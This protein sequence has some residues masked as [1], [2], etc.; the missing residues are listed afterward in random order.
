[1][2][3]ETS[4]TLDRGLRVL[5]VLSEAPDGLTVTEV[6]AAI[7]VSR[8]VTYRLIITL[9]R[10]ALVRRSADGRW[11]IGMA[12]LSLARQAQPLLREASAPALRRLADATGATAYLA[13]VDGTD[14]LIVADA[15]PTHSELHVAVRAGSRLP[16]DRSAAGRA[17]TALR[18]GRPMEPGWIGS[19]DPTTSALAI[20]APIIG[21]SGLEAVT[22]V[23]ALGEARAGDLGPLAVRAAMDIARALT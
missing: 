11:R 6:A 8:T 22:G 4:Q 10:H 17:I 16:M 2:A 7:R 3:A 5:G 23:V 21:P 14:L 1:M 19:V 20:A 18:S 12:V 13:I 9:E 15:E